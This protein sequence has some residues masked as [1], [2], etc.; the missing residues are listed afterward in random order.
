MLFHYMHSYC[1]GRL[2][3]GL[4]NP[5]G[6]SLTPGHVWNTCAK[7]FKGPHDGS[8]ARND[9]CP[10]LPADFVEFLQVLKKFTH[11]HAGKEGFQAVIFAVT[12]RDQTTASQRFL[13]DAGFE[14]IGAFTKSEGYPNCISWIVDYRKVLYPILAKVKDFEEVKNAPKFA[15]TPASI[16]QS[17]QPEPHLGRESGRYTRP[18]TGYTLSSQPIPTMQDEIRHRS[19]QTLSASTR[20]QS[21]PWSR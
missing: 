2:L 15:G 5:T 3:T 12:N 14:Q 10:H 13:P 1:G 17:I 19:E 9:P 8:N 6:V 16:N 7:D 11:F 21:T 20:R 18:T 4:Y